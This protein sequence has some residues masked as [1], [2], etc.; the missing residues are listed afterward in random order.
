MFKK[1]LTTGAIAAASLLMVA[2]ATSP[3]MAAENLVVNGGFDGPGYTDNGAQFPA[4]AAFDGWTLEYE[5]DW[6]I[7]VL[8]IWYPEMGEPGAENH[9]PYDSGPWAR[10]VGN[11]TQ[12]FPT[13]VGKTYTLDYDTRATSFGKGGGAGID[14]GSPANVRING[15][16]VDSFVTVAD[17]LISSRSVVFTA[18]SE[19]TTLSFVTTGVHVGPSG[20][21]DGAV[22]VGLDNISVTEVPENDS[23]LMAPA[24]AGGIGVAALAGGSALAVRRKNKRSSN[25]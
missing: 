11:I 21:K 12:T 20:A 17:P 24:I 4:G 22:P 6:H 16:V 15:E 23:P 5:G 14:G 7:N 9:A 2:G 3:A 25:E 10:L 18:T 19:S 13:E 8:K 1:I